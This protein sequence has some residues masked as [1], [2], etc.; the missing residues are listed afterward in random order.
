MNPIAAVILSGLAIAGFTVIV[1]SYVDAQRKRRRTELEQALFQAQRNGDC[2]EIA[3][4][5]TELRTL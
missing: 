3:R 1:G 2:A 4:L 5:V